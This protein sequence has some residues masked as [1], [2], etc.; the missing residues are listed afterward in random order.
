[1]QKPQWRISGKREGIP[2]TLRQNYTRLS[3]GFV[4]HY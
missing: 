3:N 2:Q 4:C 1:M